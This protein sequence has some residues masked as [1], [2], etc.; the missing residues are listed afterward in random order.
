MISVVLVLVLCISPV[1]AQEKSK[2]AEAAAVTEMVEAPE[3]AATE[4][5][6]EEETAA[7]VV[8]YAL[9]NMILFIATVLVLFIQAGFA[10][11]EAGLNAAKN[12]VNILFKNVM[13]LSVG[14][15]LFYIV[16]FGLMY[17]GFTDG[18]GNDFFG[19]A[20]AGVS[21]ESPAPE[22]GNLHP[23]VDFLFQVAFCST[24]ATIVSGA[25]AGRIKFG[26]YLVCSA[27]LTGFIYPISG[28][29]KWGYGWLH[30]RGST[31]LRAG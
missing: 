28:S 16:G 17:P 15:L 4:E 8:T 18:T 11:L 25:V 20:G 9:D 12:T 2:E 10:M 19:F 5:A 27:V 14:V 7:G 22:P 23:Q 3:E 26:A 31:T 29:W 24:A 1:L 30:D 21:M 13:D 6:Q